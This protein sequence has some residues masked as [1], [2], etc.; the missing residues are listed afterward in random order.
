MKN[1]TLKDGI[2]YASV[3]SLW[4]GVLG[5]YFFQYISYAGAI[6]VVIHRSLWTFVILLIT[7]W[8]IMSMFLNLH[9]MIYH[10]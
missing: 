4:W 7:T 9:Y 1:Q 5:T 8:L 3:G 10:I 6:E 2:F